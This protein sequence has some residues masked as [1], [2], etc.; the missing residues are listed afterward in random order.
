MELVAALEA[1]GPRT[2]LRIHL[3]M[4]VPGR[5]HER[6]AAEKE[7][8]AKRPPADLAQ[9]HHS[10]SPLPQRATVAGRQSMYDRA[11]HAEMLC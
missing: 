7:D 3:Q 4:H 8:H 1:P 2:P 6:L 10:S 9:R 5:I 11:L